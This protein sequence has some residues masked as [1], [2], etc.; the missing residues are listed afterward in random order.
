MQG[1]ANMLRGGL[2]ML[3]VLQVWTRFFQVI[4]LCFV[5]CSGQQAL[6]HL[7]GAHIYWGMH[8]MLGLRRAGGLLRLG[9]SFMN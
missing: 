1:F 5:S 4:V 9:C 7:K 2:Q 8:L 3:E 6:P